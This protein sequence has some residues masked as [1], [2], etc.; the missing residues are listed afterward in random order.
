M[1]KLNKSVAP[2]ETKSW[3]EE[4]LGFYDPRFELET[5]KN[6]K[7]RFKPML[8]N[9]AIF[10]GHYYDLSLSEAHYNTDPNKLT[11]LYITKDGKKEFATSA[12]YHAMLDDIRH[13]TG[14]KSISLSDI[15]DSAYLA[16]HDRKKTIDMH[17]PKKGQ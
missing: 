12:D 9:Y 4:H 15:K 11:K 13:R 1:K 17:K 8:Y 10:I 3:Q 16:A 2:T 14:R 6:G 5:L 7:I